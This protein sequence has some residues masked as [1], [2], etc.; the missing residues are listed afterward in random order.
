[1]PV[2]GAREAPLPQRHVDNRLR[3][4]NKPSDFGPALGWLRSSRGVAANGP[5]RRISGTA[6]ELVF[7][8]KAAATYDRAFT[9]RHCPGERPGDRDSLHRVVRKC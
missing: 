9:C 3:S 4:R 7:K 5:S 1:M 8:D 6:G 2:L